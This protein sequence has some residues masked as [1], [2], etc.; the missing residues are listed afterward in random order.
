MTDSNLKLTI[1]TPTYNRAKT[2]SR[3]YQ[4][5]LRQTNFDFE[6]LII[7]DGSVDDT[8]ELVSE[9]KQTNPP[10]SINY[11]SQENQGLIRTL[12]RGIQLANGTYIVKMDSDDY[13]VED[14]SETVITWI[15]SI[16]G[17]SDIYGVGGLRINPKGEPLRGEW[18]DI[19]AQ[20][21]YR[22]AT[23]LERNKYRLDA[24][25]TEAWRT[26]VLRAHPFPVWPGEKFAPEQIV[27]F[28]IALEKLKIRWFLKPLTI[29][30]YREDGLTKG[31]F[32]LEKDNPMGFAMMY[33]QRL[34][35]TERLKDRFMTACQLT[36]LSAV[37]H[38]LN[39]LLK[40][41]DLVMTFWSLIPG[42][43]LSIRCFS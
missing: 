23:D 42:L 31:S 17:L 24:D 43:L 6:W 34:K 40:S 33:N 19:P 1:F 36:A 41:N 26:D 14:F 37:G 35:Y 12:N 28:D 22:D 20:L 2:L 30:E 13:V 38:N 27:F 39:Y 15:R 4:S 8:D 7:N 11:Y 29:C 16:E 5:L 21:G 3:L 25:M 18:P 32:Q 10:F 9:W